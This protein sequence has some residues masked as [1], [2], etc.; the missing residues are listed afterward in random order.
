MSFK[1]FSAQ[2]VLKINDQAAIDRDRETGF[3]K[4]PHDCSDS[5]GLRFAG[6]VAQ[7]LR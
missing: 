2:A 5:L 7:K 6:N 3:D 4:I 1:G